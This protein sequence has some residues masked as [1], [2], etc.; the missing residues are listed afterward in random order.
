MYAEGGLYKSSADQSI[1][2]MDV[3]A[4][5]ATGWCESRRSLAYSCHDMRAPWRCVMSLTRGATMQKRTWGRYL[6]MVSYAL[7]PRP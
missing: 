2:R 6:T 7:V 1:A 3:L 4:S 5:M